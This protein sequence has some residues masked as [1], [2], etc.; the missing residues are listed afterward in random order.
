MTSAGSTCKIFSAVR[1]R[2]MASISPL[3]RPLKTVTSSPLPDTWMT[4][5]TCVF[6]PAAIVTSCWKGLKPT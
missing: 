6:L 3:S 1:V 5:L 2:L 4:A